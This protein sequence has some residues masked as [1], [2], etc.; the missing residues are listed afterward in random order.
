M[1]CFSFIFLGFRRLPAAEDRLQGVIDWTG[2][3]KHS[4]RIST[5][6]N[7]ASSTG[8]TGCQQQHVSAHSPPWSGACSS[9]PGGTRAR[10]PP[11]A[12][13]R[14][15]PSSARGTV[16][17]GPAQAGRRRDD[18]AI[19]RSRRAGGVSSR[20]T[21]GGARGTGKGG[22]DARRWGD[23]RSD[24]TV[25]VDRARARAAQRSTPHTRTR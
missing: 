1:Y 21:L 23:T 16:R 11:R 4:T 8:P 5:E 7:R 19:A 6:D 17:A 25:V 3:V 18:A 10:A 22:M 9:S 15:S 14:A 12:R 13:T 24:H 2:V 20:Q